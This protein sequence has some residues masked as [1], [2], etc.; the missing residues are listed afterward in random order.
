MKIQ[1]SLALL[2]LATALHVEGAPP[3]DPFAD[4][5]PSTPEEIERNRPRNMLFCYETFSMPL[6]L[7]AKFQ[8]ED[9][10]DTEIYTQ[11]TAAAEKDGVRQESFIMSRSRSGM[12]SEATSIREEI[13]PSAYMSP[14]MPATVGVAIIPPEVKDVPTPV[15]DVAKLKDAPPLDGV[16]DLRAP[17]T[18][19][20]FETRNVGRILEIGANLSDGPNPIMEVRTVPEQVVMVGRHTWGQG[21]SKVEMPVFEKQ[22]INTSITARANEPAL[23]GTFNRPPVSQVDPDSAKR[24]WLAF[25]TVTIVK[26]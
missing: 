12:S 13:Y 5:G 2:I 26:L 23:I 1:S 8:R 9:K 24:V 22:S 10:T 4:G 7:A 19:S 16:G 11:L 25:V 6:A 14:N 18:A 17:A 3:A 21:L 20:S 15:P